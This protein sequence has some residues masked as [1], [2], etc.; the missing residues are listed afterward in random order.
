MD[1]QLYET[2]NNQYNCQ[3]FKISKSNGPAGVLPQVLF[4]NYV[5]NTV[6]H[7]ITEFI[8][9]ILNLILNY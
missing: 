8:T 4:Y 1:I 2:M 5:M 6:L 3:K 7:L 9:L